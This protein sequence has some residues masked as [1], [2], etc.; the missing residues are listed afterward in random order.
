MIISCSIASATNLSEHAGSVN[1][2][3]PVNQQIG[4]GGGLDKV[5]A[6]I[7]EWLTC[8]RQKVVLNE[9]KSELGVWIV[10][11]SVPDFQQ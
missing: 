11:G 9:K 4:G 1:V 10:G 2:K 6:C 7:M 8:R 5:L 3:R